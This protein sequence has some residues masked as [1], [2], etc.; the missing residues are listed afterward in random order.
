MPR[1]KQAARQRKTAKFE[2]VIDDLRQKL[3]EDDDHPLL[4]NAVEALE[5]A[6]SFVTTYAAISDKLP[7]ACAA[8]WL[9]DRSHGHVFESSSGHVA[10]C[11]GPSTCTQC[12]LEGALL[13]LMGK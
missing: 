11:G 3:M 13:R 8:Q 6:R 2:K 5:A 10:R 12:Q 7:I 4:V 1:K 9:L